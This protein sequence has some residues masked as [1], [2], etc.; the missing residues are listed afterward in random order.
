MVPGRFSWFSWLQVGFSLFLVNFYGSRSVF[1][2]F[3]DSWL[4]FYGP[5]LVFMIFNGSRSLLHGS[6]SIFIVFHGF[7]VGFNGFSWFQVGNLWFLS[8]MYLPELYPGLA[9]Q[10]RT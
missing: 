10:S 9:V 3:H 2:V 1:M 8:K 5:R 4:V 7:Q 6:R